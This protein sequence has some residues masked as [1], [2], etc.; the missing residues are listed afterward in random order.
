VRSIGGLW[1]V[2]EGRADF[3]GQPFMSLLTLG[4]DTS[5]GHFVGSW[6]DTNQTTMWT[7][8]G[9]LDDARKTLTLE[10]EGP[11][12]TDA[13]KLAKYRDELTLE[14]KDHKVMKSTILG[15]DGKWTQYM[16]ADYRRTK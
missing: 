3:G 6:V 12:H 16:K 13:N 11:S 10:A 4:Y 2:G 8:K 5:K 15:D 1:V 7:Y 14:S 9:K